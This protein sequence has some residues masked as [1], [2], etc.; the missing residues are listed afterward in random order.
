MTDVFE[1]LANAIIIQAVKDYRFALK[2]LAKHP[3]NDSALYTK[4]EVER[5]FHSGFFSNLT[6]LNPEML[7]RKLQEEVV[8]R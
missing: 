7:I 6:S 8:R 5:F 1:K 4:R 3:R 2:K